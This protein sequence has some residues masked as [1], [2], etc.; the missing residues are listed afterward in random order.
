MNV[1]GVTAIV[2]SELNLPPALRSALFCLSRGV[3]IVAHALE[4]MQSGG[5]IR[6]PSP[7]PRG[8]L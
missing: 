5:R 6:G 3:G 8:R 7:P 1:D 4:E 2:Y